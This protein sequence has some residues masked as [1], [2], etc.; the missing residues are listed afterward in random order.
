LARGDV[1]SAAIFRQFFAN[2]LPMTSLS[3]LEEPDHWL[4]RATE[5]RLLAD[6]MADVQ[7]KA[8]MLKIAEN[9][10]KLALRA[11]QRV[12]KRV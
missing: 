7:S 6:A 3:A 12:V 10:E 1:E 11:M 8:V 5:V 9:Y 4:K 2:A